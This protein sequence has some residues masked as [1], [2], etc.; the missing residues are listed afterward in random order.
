[1]I[2]FLSKILNKTGN[3]LIKISG[4]LLNRNKSPHQREEE[5]NI[6][7]WC[8]NNGDKTHRINYNLNETSLVFDM[9]GYEGQWT[10]DIY[11]R[12]LCEVFIFEPNLSF[13]KNIELRFDR[14]PKIKVFSFGLSDTTREEFINVSADATSIYKSGG[15]TERISL[16]QA[17]EF[18]MNNGITRIDLMKI[19]IE[20]GEYDLL[21][22]LIESD[23]IKIIDN[24]QVQFHWF[25]P[26]AENRMKKIQSNLGLTHY[27]TYEY[28]YVWENW[29]RKNEIQ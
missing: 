17:S 2:V 4:D 5:I 25:F 16:V 11:S 19:N 28:K 22:H 24:I 21:D 3:I 29:K 13:S 18:F 15:K 10:S 7:K 6:V 23:L 1:M 8:A 26:D 12:Y 20:G 14:N 9:G 27:Q